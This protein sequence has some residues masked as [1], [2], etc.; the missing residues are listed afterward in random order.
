MVSLPPQLAFAKPKKSTVI[1]PEGGSSYRGEAISKRMKYCPE[2]ETGNGGSFGRTS[3][4]YGQEPSNF[5]SSLEVRTEIGKL[6]PSAFVFCLSMRFYQ[7]A[8]ARAVNI[9]DVLQVNDNSCRARREKIVNGCTKAVALFSE[10]KTPSKCQKMDAI[11]FAL[12]YFQRHGRLSM[13]LSNMGTP[14]VSAMVG[15]SARAAGQCCS[16]DTTLR[17]RFHWDLLSRSFAGAQIL[18]QIESALG[19]SSRILSHACR[20]VNPPTIL[21]PYGGADINLRSRTHRL[22]LTAECHISSR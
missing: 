9:I 10:H 7:C 21:L 20:Q 14:S 11:Q 16:L 6:Q 4:K 12:C 8:K 18:P 2:S 5:Q 17:A 22:A 15:K 3:F 13:R 19:E 1:R